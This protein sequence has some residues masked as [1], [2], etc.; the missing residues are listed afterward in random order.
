MIATLILQPKQRR[1][2]YAAQYDMRLERMKHFVPG[3]GSRSLTLDYFES[4]CQFLGIEVVKMRMR[5]LYGQAIWAGSE[6][7]IYL[8]SRLSY[9]EMTVTAY[10]ELGHI[11]LHTFKSDF[12]NEDFILN[13]SKIEAQASAV[14]LISLM[15]RSLI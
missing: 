13:L 3:F 11:L 15:P 2:K 5:R 4:Y 6:L 8:N 10:H 14:G 7:F 1:R 9:G 12:P